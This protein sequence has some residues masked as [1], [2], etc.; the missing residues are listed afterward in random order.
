MD[1][2]LAD[3]ERET[4]ERRR[5]VTFPVAQERWD[6]IVLPRL[7]VRDRRERDHRERALGSDEKREMP[8]GRVTGDDSPRR[9]DAVEVRGVVGRRQDVVE[10]AGPAAARVSD[11]PVL[12]VEGRIALRTEGDAEVACVGELYVAFQAPPCTTIRSG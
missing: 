6:G 3:P 7:E 4:A 5:T 9:I 2:D 11:P 10:A 8:A 1:D 12:D